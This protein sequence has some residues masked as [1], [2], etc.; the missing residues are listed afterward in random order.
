MLKYCKILLIS[1]PPVKAFQNTFFY[2]GYKPPGYEP[3]QN[4]LQSCISPGLISRILGYAGFNLKQSTY[5]G[6]YANGTKL[7]GLLPS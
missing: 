2:P 4:P 3:P 6:H 5:V 7:F 1:P